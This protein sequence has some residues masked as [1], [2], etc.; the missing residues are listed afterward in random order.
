LPAPFVLLAP[1]ISAIVAT[2]PT[3]VYGLAGE[4]LIRQ[5]EVGDARYIVASG[6]FAGR[7]RRRARDWPGGLARGV[8][9]RGGVVECADNFF[10][11]SPAAR[12]VAWIQARWP[13]VARA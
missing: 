6:Q 9:G 5:D 12:A 1:E 4:T 2:A 13:D 3:W 7:G 8:L 11:D 10:Q